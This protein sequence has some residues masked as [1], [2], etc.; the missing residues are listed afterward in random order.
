MNAVFLGSGYLGGDGG[1][2]D[3]AD[4]RRWQKFFAASLERAIVS[5]DIL[6]YARWLN[7]CG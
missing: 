2:A 4:A 5:T 3:R 7:H 6:I 1:L